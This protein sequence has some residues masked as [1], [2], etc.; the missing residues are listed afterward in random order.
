VSGSASG[1]GEPRCGKQNGNRRC[2]DV[3]RIGECCSQWGFCG[4][5]AYHCVT[6]LGCQAECND[7]LD[8]KLESG[9]SD[10]PPVAVVPKQDPAAATKIIIKQI[11]PAVRL[12]PNCANQNPAAPAQVDPVLQSLS[13]AIA[14]DL[15]LSAQA[16]PMNAQSAYSSAPAHSASSLSAS[17]LSAS[18]HSGISSLGLDS[19]NLGSE[20]HHSHQARH[21]HHGQL[22]PAVYKKE[23]AGI[24]NVVEQAASQA[25]QILAAAQQQAAAIQAGTQVSATRRYAA[26]PPSSQASGVGGSMEPSFSERKHWEDMSHEMRN[27]VRKGV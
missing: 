24:K 21:R 16:P 26:M 13:P 22:S 19:L 27:E 23:I 20:S 4:K 15:Q 25:A 14:K 17:S 7:D 18:S 12:C 3:G 2:S 10:A 5:K 8:S 9:A 1:N 11:M 6:R